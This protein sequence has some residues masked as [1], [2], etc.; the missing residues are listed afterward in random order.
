MC[1][2]ESTYE[3]L[4]E[5]IETRMM[6]SIWRI[7]RNTEE[8]ED[9]MQEALTIIWRRWERICRHPNPEALILKI[10]IDVAYDSLRTQFRRHRMGDVFKIMLLKT[11]DNPLKA[12]PYEELIGQETEAEVLRAIARLPR[13]QAVAALLRILYEQSYSDI[14]STMGCSEATVRIHVSRARARL[15]RWLSHLNPGYLPEVSQ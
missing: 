4:I 5:T 11:S 8:A 15:C 13:R 9:A 1:Y 6:R 12:S 10:S 14:A 7:V 2:K 3:E